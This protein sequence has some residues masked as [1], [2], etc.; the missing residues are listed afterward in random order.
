MT[1]LSARLTSRV[2]IP[3]GARFDPSTGNAGLP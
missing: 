1:R 3:A 2:L